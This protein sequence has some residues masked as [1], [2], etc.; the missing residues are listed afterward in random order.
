M[1]FVVL[2]AGLINSRP[3]AQPASFKVEGSFL[4]VQ[5]SGGRELW[6]KVFASP[7]TASEDGRQAWFGDLDEDGTTEV[8]F[9]PRTQFG[10]AVPLICYS[11]QGDEKWRFV[12]GRATASPVE[13]FA[14]I[15]VVRQ[16][17]VFDASPG[18]RMVAV[19]SHHYLYYPNQ[20]ALLSPAGKLL[21]EYWHSGHLSS[22][23]VADFEGDGVREIY[24]GGVSNGYRA[25]TLVV[26]DPRSFHGASVE[27]AAPDDQLQGF[28]PGNE[29]ARIVFPR[30]CI[31]Q[32][33]EQYNGVHDVV[34]EPERIVVRVAE[35][36]SSFSN[37][38]YQFSRNLELERVVPSDALRAFHQELESAGKLDHEFGPV[39][40]AELSG[41]QDLARPALSARR[42]RKA[43]GAAGRPSSRDGR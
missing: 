30:T 42:S 36:K 12:P 26:L 7:L 29:R 4:I 35:K 41:V 1:A 40:L 14:P 24:L 8:L 16:F 17:A 6:R 13:N 37:V 19:T 32:M 39:E 28:A 3:N 10:A 33:F 34:M 21:R 23:G 27:T 11:H 43:S 5:D 20:V 18:R 38:I 2:A 9:A 22:L 25:A 31:S 15:F